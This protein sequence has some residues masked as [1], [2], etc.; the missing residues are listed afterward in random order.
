MN[1]LSQAFERNKKWLYFALVATFLWGM[2]AHG[3]SFFDNSF[4][5]DSLNELHGAI[6]GNQLK[7]G[8]G[9][10][11]IP[12]Y[13][14]LFRSDVTLPWLIG[15]LSLLWLG[16]TVFLVLRLFRVESKGMAFLIAGIFTT[17]I[18][19]SATAATYIQD[20]DGNMFSLL[21]AVAAV[22]LW[23]KLPRGWLYGSILISLS[24]GIYQS[25]LFAGVAL[26]MIV[27]ILDLLEGR[28]FREVFAQGLKAI[29]MILLGGILYFLLM[30]LILRSTGLS[31]SS[32]DYNSL[33]AVTKLTPAIIVQM[34]GEAYQDWFARLMNAY[35][36]YPAFLVK[37]ITILLFAVCGI[38]V[39]AAVCS[40]K[41]GWAEKGLMLCLLALLPLGMNMI[42]VL[43]QGAVHDLTAYAIWLFYLLVLLL[44]DWLVKQWKVSKAKCRAGK[45]I[46]ITCL[47]L[48]C[49][50]LY[51]NVQ[52]AN[53]MYLK[54]DLEY[55]AYLSLMTR[56]VGRMEDCEDYIPGET[57]V[58]F[59]GMPQALNAV[60]P[61]FKDYWNV[62]GMTSPDVIFMPE[63]TRF[64]A[65][66]HY[67]LGLPLQLADAEVWHSVR[68]SELAA[69]MP[70]YPAEGS[71]QF[72]NGVLVV[73]LGDM[74][75]E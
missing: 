1:R 17:N 68:Q 35:S 21:C 51:G 24:L 65:Y 33:D 36:T 70:I 2:L 42:Y 59:V 72:H 69:Q 14:D 47:L 8:S 54:K 41:I 28:S 48:V 30:K 16:L 23:R 39:A 7:M 9:R 20:L 50:L 32:G 12:I 26:V 63:P 61:G 52:F 11:F 3:Y 27:C 10:V 40:I 43:L 67:V 31:L 6:V 44:A 25:I 37:G 73:K 58:V 57:E 53:G 38:A 46:R 49:L 55:D 45:G 34:V 15:V 18:S 29:G 75:S 62:T 19:V 66:F 64:E 13:R 56:V 71:I 22:V 5:H 60:M 4:S 74:P